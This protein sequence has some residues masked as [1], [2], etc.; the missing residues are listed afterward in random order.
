[1][2]L[3]ILSEEDVFKTLNEPQAL[4][5]TKPVID[6]LVEQFQSYLSDTE[7]FTANSQNGE[8][9]FMLSVSLMKNQDEGT[10]FDFYVMEQNKHE[11]VSGVPVSI[12]D[13]LGHT[14][15]TFFKEDRD[16]RLPID[17]TPFN[18]GNTDVYARQVHHHF[19][20]EKQA[21]EW[22]KKNGR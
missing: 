19:A 22:L 8:N 6:L 14:L 21:D 11:L 15:E 7:Y 17:F 13:F 16:A 5:T 20:L 9:A 10:V 12:L 3:K 4:Q 1:M 2:N 18:V